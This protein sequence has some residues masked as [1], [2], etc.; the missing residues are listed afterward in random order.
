[1]HSD[2]EIKP[3]L[4]TSQYTDI[5]VDILITECHYICTGGIVSNNYMLLFN[6]EGLCGQMIYTINFI[7]HIPLRSVICRS[8]V[9][10]LTLS[11]P[12]LSCLRNGDPITKNKL[13]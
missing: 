9:S 2:S 4:Y 13:F 7:Y 10:N 3:L 6:I 1:M 12:L 11:I 8:K 5:E